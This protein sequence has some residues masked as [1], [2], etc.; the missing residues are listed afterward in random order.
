MAASS[1]RLRRATLDDAAL[2]ADLGARTFRDAYRDEADGTALEAFIAE[3]FGPAVQ[4]A[5]L[6]EPSNRAV[7]A[8]VDAVA[9]GYVFLRDEAPEVPIGGERPILLSR[10]Y[11]DASAQGRGVGRA[12]FAWALEE[13]DRLGRDVLW[14][15]VWER[16]PRA[17]AIY[18][19]WGFEHRGEIPFEF[20]GDTH[21]DLVMAR[22]IGGTA[23]TA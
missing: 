2:L 8:T 13:A 21:R 15:T 11:V 7:I 14:L 3:A 20:A 9:V 16:N 5:E 18:E 22:P 10:L 19:R 12:L 17:I 23:R 4:A 6:A 1:V